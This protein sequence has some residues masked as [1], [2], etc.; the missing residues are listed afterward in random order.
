MVVTE[1]IIQGFAKMAE[2]NRNKPQNDNI[3]NAF[4]KWLNS[5][6]SSLTPWV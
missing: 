3:T 1:T 2:Q 4:Q 5:K 6:L